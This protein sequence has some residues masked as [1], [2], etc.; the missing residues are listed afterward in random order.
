MSKKPRRQNEKLHIDALDDGAGDGR[1]YSLEEIMREFGGWSKREE[2]EEEKD[3]P[4]Q[5]PQEQPVGDAP[6]VPED[7]EEDETLRTEAPDGQTPAGPSLSERKKPAERPAIVEFPGP[8]SGG[9]D[10]APENRPP[11]RKKSPPAEGEKGPAAGKKVPRQKAKKAPPPEKS[12][13][14]AQEAYRQTRQVPAFLRL[15]VAA[16]TLICGAS[17]FFMLFSQGGWSLAGWRLG[18]ETA[19]VLQLGSMLLAMVMA[20]EVLI[21]GMS[22][23]VRLRFDLDSLVS[24]SAVVMGVHGFTAISSGQMPFC[25]VG[26]LGLL[27]GLWNDLLQRQAQRSS[28]KTVQNQPEITGVFV[29]D[30]VWQ[31]DRCVVRG[32]TEPDRIVPPLLGGALPERVMR[33]YAPL[34]LV[35]S[36]TMA[37]LAWAKREV[38][39]LWAWSAI[40]SA[41][42]PVGG[43]V[44][45]SRP[46]ARLSKRLCRS[47][48]ALCGWTG[49]KALRR[50]SAVIL[51][52]GDLFPPANI[53]MSGMKIFGDHNV[54][55]VVGYISAVMT[56][57]GGGLVPVFQSLMQTQN[58]RNCVLDQFRR[59][60]A[61]GLGA[62]IYGDVVL[63]GSLGFM[64]LMG[65][66]MEE[67]TKVK[68]AVYISINGELAGVF[69][70][71]YAPSG[72]ARSALASLCR[73]RRL[74][75]LLAVRDFMLTPAMLHKKYQVPAG[76]MEYPAVEKRMELALAEPDETACLGAVMVRDSSLPLSEVLTGGR[77]LWLVTWVGTVIS[78]VS[79][80]IGLF[81]MSFLAYLGAAATACGFNA[82]L[83][84]L[85]WLA[86][87]LLLTQWVRG[88]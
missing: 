41:C 66:H 7:R 11:R 65:V 70:L 26:S 84:V 68:Q 82:M 37:A 2:P 4:S 18:G 52:D 24:C 46:F 88:A 61:G 13:P 33:F 80:T 5:Q 77:T 74:K 39:F 67:G 48:A 81:M 47:G 50:A 38:D 42:I 21:K 16:L 23:C 19:A 30:R 69:A 59:Y 9:E 76:A 32:D 64:Q 72:A 34:A 75:T 28:L 71:N 85:I 40:L 8:L 57:A 3:A 31:K 86:P 27:F 83:Y 53:S 29:Q 62:E 1:E 20:P 63:V 55:V 35:I 87:M 56:E 73:S 25:V 54:S 43:M 6:A 36:L 78:V 79:G 60:E 22:Q 49:A 12:W 17:V 51:K 45:F 15:R 44:A 14:T 58:G 10:E